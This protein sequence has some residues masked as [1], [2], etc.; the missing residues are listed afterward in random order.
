MK[1]SILITGASSGLG[2]ALAH[3]YAQENTRLILIG[4]DENRLMSVAMQCRQKGAVVEFYVCDVTAREKIHAIISACDESAPIDLVICNAG[5][6]GGTGGA[7]IPRALAQSRQIFDVN[8]MGVL[9][10]LDPLLPCMME[11]QAG[12]VAIISSLASFLPLPNAPAYGASKTAVRL[13]AEA[14]RGTLA[15]FNVHVTVICPG[16]V[17]TR[18]TDDNRYPMPFLME[19]AAAAAL[20]AKR[21]K[22]APLRIIF[23]LPMTILIYFLRIIPTNILIWLMKK[24]PAKN[25]LQ[26]R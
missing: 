16:F 22:R 17:K 1:K 10:T 3:Y 8:M 9:N 4:R 23:P 19:A 5:I 6:S 24:A 2:A 20:I 26:P 7:D 12:Q 13:Y 15:P 25:A 11:R 18:M 21:L 14:L